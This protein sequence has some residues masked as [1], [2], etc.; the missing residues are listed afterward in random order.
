MMIEEFYNQY[1]DGSIE[2]ETTL[3]GDT[4]YWIKLTKDDSE[5]PYSEVAVK[6][7]LE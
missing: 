3:S 4:V 5:T 2:E 6:E 1:P 7:L